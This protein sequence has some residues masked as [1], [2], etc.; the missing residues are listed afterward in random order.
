VGLTNQNPHMTSTAT[1]AETQRV[2]EQWYCDY[3]DRVQR[4]I[5]SIIHRKGHHGEGD[6]EMRA[7]LNYWIV[8]HITSAARRGVID[9]VLPSMAID[10]AYRSWS[11]GKRSYHDRQGR[12]DLADE[13]PT[14]QHGDE[15]RFPV[16][17]RPNDPAMRARY[18]L[19]MQTIGRRLTPNA[20]RVLRAFI[21]DP[22]AT[23][24][25]VCEALGGRWRPQYVFHY[26]QA[27]KRAM[28]IAGYLP[29]PK[30]PVQAPPEICAIGLTAAC[31]Y[32]ACQRTPRASYVEIARRLGCQKSHVRWAVH[33]FVAAGVPWAEQFRANNSQERCQQPR[34]AALE[35]SSCA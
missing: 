8:C 10:Y 22:H 34:R 35:L 24:K 5:G 2:V 1:R 23:D 15:W 17:K 7:E 6:D 19:D 4:I 3:N 32:D 13:T 28:V 16:S 26:R 12:H 18:H 20:Q 25:R 9:R 11:S 21:K 31:V 33:K 29:P 27:I 14:E 30:R